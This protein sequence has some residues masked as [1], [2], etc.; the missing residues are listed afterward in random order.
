M[1]KAA[2]TELHFVVDDALA[3]M[4]GAGKVS[5]S[6]LET[7]R[8]E[9]DMS[10]LRLDAPAEDDALLTRAASKRS[11]VIEPLGDDRQP[12][13]LLLTP[14]GVGV[15]TVNGRRATRVCLMRVG[16]QL[17]LD[18]GRLLHLTAFD[19]PRVGEPSDQQL[20]VPC[21]V[22]RTPIDKDARVYSCPCGSTLHYDDSTDAGDND[23]LLCATLASECMS[24]RRPINLNGGFRY[25]P[26]LG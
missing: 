13:L 12:L 26:D 3:T 16:D 1:K 20:G 11:L 21:P 9:C 5:P 14:P 2:A 19:T 22:C 23:R 10:H 18:D 24:C 7:L 25:V 4:T 6:V 15:P 8:V 17:L